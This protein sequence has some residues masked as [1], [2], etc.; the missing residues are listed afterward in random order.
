MARRLI[1]DMLLPGLRSS[2]DLETSIQ[3]YQDGQVKQMSAP[4]TG[5][6]QMSAHGAL[7]EER[8]SPR[9]PSPRGVLTARES[10]RWVLIAR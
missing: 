4:G 3:G 8:T 7:T 1:P 6:K 9:M 2:Y 10:S 5:V